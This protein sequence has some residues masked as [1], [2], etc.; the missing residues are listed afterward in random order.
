MTRS[1]LSPRPRALIVEDEILIALGLEAD[2]SELGYDVRGLAANARDALSLAMD[3]TPDIA[4]I[5]I[6]LNGTRDGI[7]TARMLRELCGV[8]VVFVTA[9]S[10]E[11]GIAERIE[12]QV[13]GAPILNKP[14]FGHRLADAINKVAKA[15][16]SFGVQRAAPELSTVAAQ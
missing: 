8:P 2:L 3:N 12:R 15:A 7:E 14:L 5:D 11:E 13:P 9:F 10:D 1:S 6:Y 16:P 4:V